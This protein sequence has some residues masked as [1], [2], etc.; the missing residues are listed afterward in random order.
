MQC[1]VLV[2]VKQRRQ[3]LVLGV[4]VW[5]CEHFLFS[6]VRLIARD[7][8]NED[9]IVKEGNDLIWNLIAEF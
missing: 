6:R 4:I 2:A 7:L 9:G 8:K 1:L 3:G 5:L